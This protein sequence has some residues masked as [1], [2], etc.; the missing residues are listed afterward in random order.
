MKK[1]KTTEDW[2]WFYFNHGF[3]VL[4]LKQRAKTPNILEWKSYEFS[5]ADKKIVQGWLNDG[6]FE[7]IGVQCG[8]ASKG[9]CVI[10]LDSQ[11][12]IKDLNIKLDS[13]INSGCWVST[14]GRGY[15]LW[16]LNSDEP[17]NTVLDGEIHADFKTTG[18]IVVPPS[19]HPTG[20]HYEFINKSFNEL[21]PMKSR[22]VFEDMRKKLRKLYKIKDVK[23]EDID[24]KENIKAKCIS[25]LLDG[26]KK[27][28]RD[29]SA[30]A[31]S[32]FYYKI[33]KLDK[34]AVYAVVREWNEKNRPP[35]K[36]D[37]IE[38]CINS[39]IVFDGQT[40]C[41]KLRS[42]RLCPYEYIKECSFLYPDGYKEPEIEL[43]LSK[44][45]ENL[46]EIHERLRKWLFIDDTN[47]IDLILAAMLSNKEKESKPLWIFIIGQS[48]DSKSEILTG[49]KGYPDVI[50]LDRITANTFATGKTHKGKKL[51]D[52][53]QK[54]DNSSHIILFSDL[55][56]LKSVNKNDKDEIWGQL[57]ELYD[58]RINKITGNATEAIYN[59]CHVTLVACS[60]PDIRDEYSI[61]NN[62]GTREL[63]Y[64]IEGRNESVDEKML[65]A[66]KHLGHETE[67]KK[68]IAESVQGFI[69]NREMDM[70][71]QPDEKMLQ[72]LMLK[73]KE[74]AVMR[75]SGRW[76]KVTGELAGVYSREV[77]TRLI[78]QLL[79][80]YKAFYSLEKD[81]PIKKFKH[82]I[83]NIVTAS[84]DSIRQKLFMFFK[85]LGCDIEY[86]IEM[87]HEELN[88]G[89]RTIKRQ[90][91]LLAA[92]NILDRRFTDETFGVNNNL[93]HRV[94]YY[95]FKR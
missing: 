89:K 28:S 72:W 70:S 40:G 43:D 13:I 81:Y 8:I 20:K 9:L 68:E 58:G 91:E 31:L 27:G 88:L 38:K 57:R 76:E 74:L 51:P 82:I 44:P 47:R 66:I 26:V 92:M 15:H 4:P 41:R 83:N 63:C 5:R 77:P 62:L 6:L 67:M 50:I 61:H 2:V 48:G 71:I 94:C 84:G 25:K 12:I 34:E 11:K 22:M 37:E 79:L 93:E 36:N 24:D 14:T 23:A 32:Q 30:F 69:T 80:L 29:I 39:G 90:C 21:K 64:E 45:P 86:T 1:L 49:F 60:T 16:T 7:N 18:Y 75:A 53:G 46:A 52:L 59:N 78:Q 65:A 3:G 55:A 35:L 73:S 10:D 17:G 87:L 95:R 85:K 54:L 56:C 42:L 19:I 33:K